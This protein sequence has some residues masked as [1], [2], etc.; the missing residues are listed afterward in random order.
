MLDL[1]GHD[2][3]AYEEL[4]RFQRTQVKIADLQATGQARGL[5]KTV[6]AL[7]PSPAR[8]ELAFR[9]DG[10]LE[11]KTDARPIVIDAARGASSTASPTCASPRRSSRSRRRSRRG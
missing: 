1:A 6:Y 2:A 9:P 3:K 4:T 5:K 11:V 10:M 8:A 7:V